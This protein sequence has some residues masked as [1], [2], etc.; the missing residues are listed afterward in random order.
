[1]FYTQ[2]NVHG[3][4]QTITAVTFNC[5]VNVVSVQR[6]ITKNTPKMTPRNTCQLTAF[7]RKRILLLD[8][9]DI[10]WLDATLGTV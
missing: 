5:N 1:M 9:V 10:R 7:G 2:H 6:T 8:A 3:Y 4:K